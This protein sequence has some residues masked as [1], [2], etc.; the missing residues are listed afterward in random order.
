[1]DLKKINITKKYFY[2]PK[3]AGKCHAL[4]TAMNLKRVKYPSARHLTAYR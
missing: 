3:L 2:P 4:H 1:M